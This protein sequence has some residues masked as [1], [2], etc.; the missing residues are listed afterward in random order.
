MI[1]KGREKSN[2][3]AFLSSSPGCD[4][5]DA[6][7]CER[8][9]YKNLIGTGELNIPTEIQC[10]VAYLEREQSRKLWEKLKKIEIFQHLNVNIPEVNGDD[11]IE[12]LVYYNKT[13]AICN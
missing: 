10:K 3:L 2:K 4:N 1:N 8:C 12:S 11:P 13:K 5:C 6:Y 9:I 7:H